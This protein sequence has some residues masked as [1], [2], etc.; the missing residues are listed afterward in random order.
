MASNARTIDGNCAVL[1]LPSRDQSRTPLRSLFGGTCT[2]ARMPS[3][4]GSYNRPR[5]INGGSARVAS[6]GRTVAGFSVHFMA[7]GSG[8]R[9]QGTFNT[10]LLVCTELHLEP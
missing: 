2:S 8:L 7:Q 10:L 3:Y 6:I 5:P 9:A 4:F 1:S